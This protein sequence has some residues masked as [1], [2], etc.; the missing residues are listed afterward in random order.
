VDELGAIEP[1]RRGE[2]SE[3]D[4]GIVAIAVD[5]YFRELQLIVRVPTE[6]VP[7]DDEVEVLVQNIVARSDLPLPSDLV[8]CLWI[9][10]RGLYKIEI[11]Y[12]L[13]GLR[14]GIKWK[15]AGARRPHPKATQFIKQAQE[16]GDKL[17]K[18]FYDGLADDRLL[19]RAAVAVYV[20]SDFKSLNR[21][22]YYPIN[23]SSPA[24][25]KISSDDVVALAWRAGVVTVA[26]RGQKNSG[27]PIV[28]FRPGE[29]AI[30]AVPVRFGISWTSDSPWG[31]VRVGIA[32]PTAEVS[33][34]LNADG[35]GSLEA[36]LLHASLVMLNE[37]SI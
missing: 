1:A 19:A 9:V 34:L 37:A 20:S 6:Y 25:V 28:G 33:Y 30:L 15:L 29:T 17:A 35:R 4:Y 24:S 23:A 36:S 18:A 21:T 11:P 8:N 10:G 12:P 31:V 14:Y 3:Q 13:R 2:F 16:N 32:A 27:T 5:N 26:L 22:G 7:S